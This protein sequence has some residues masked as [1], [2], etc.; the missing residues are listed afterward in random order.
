MSNAQAHEAIQMS[1]LRP[2]NVKLVRQCFRSIWHYNQAAGHLLSGVDITNQS[3]QLARDPSPMFW[4]NW[5]GRQSTT[6]LE[7]CGQRFPN[8]DAQSDSQ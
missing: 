5:D 3:A 8:K 4:D 1:A 7:G 6:I 2:G